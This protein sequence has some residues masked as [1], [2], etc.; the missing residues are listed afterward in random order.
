MIHTLLPHDTTHEKSMLAAVR[1][2]L[3]ALYCPDEGW[4]IFQRFRWNTNI[5]EMIIQK[6]GKKGCERILVSL[7]LKQG[8]NLSQHEIQQLT[9]RLQHDSANRSKCIL[10][11]EDR[12]TARSIPADM[13]VVSL[14]DMLQPKIRATE[15]KLVA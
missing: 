2:S 10:V 15:P 14:E 7:L 6:E 5:P 1:E 9:Y 3:A 8:S 11:V 4:K 13:E 12:D